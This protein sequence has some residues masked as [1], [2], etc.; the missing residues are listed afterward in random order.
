[1]RARHDDG[2]PDDPIHGPSQLVEDVLR[3]LEEANC[4]TAINDQ[5]V[6]LIE[7]WELQLSPQTGQITPEKDIT[8]KPLKFTPP[9]GPF[10]HVEVQ[11]PKTDKWLPFSEGDFP[12]G[13]PE[14]KATH[15]AEG[16]EKNYPGWKA[17]KIKA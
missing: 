14:K 8:M 15:M 13:L 10:F 4:P 3:L 6:K 1:M 2:G 7:E 5:I 12:G 16:I 9:T 11:E 17:R